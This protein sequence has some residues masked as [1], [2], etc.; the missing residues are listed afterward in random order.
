M[1]KVRLALIALSASL[2]MSTAGMASTCAVTNVTTS[3]ACLNE[4][5]NNENQNLNTM[6]SGGLFGI[7]NWSEVAGSVG[8]GSTVGP[9]TSGAGTQSGTWSVTGFGGYS[10]ALLVVKGGNGFAAYWLDTLFTSGTWST[11]GLT[12]GNGNNPDLSHLA[13]YEGGTQVSQTPIPGALW[14]MGSV[15]AGMA[16]LGRWRRKDPPALAAM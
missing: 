8:A 13:L 2:L 12:V 5:G 1:H 10:D 15:L 14:L 3:T 7:S 9:L 6:V 16:G 11:L 4:S